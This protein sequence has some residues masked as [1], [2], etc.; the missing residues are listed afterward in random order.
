MPDRPNVLFIVVDQFRADLLHGALAD[1][2]DLPNLRALMADSVSFAQHYSV[3]SPCGPAR[4]SLLT[5]QYAMN[6]GV[7]RNGTPLAHDTPNIAREARRAGY[8]PLLFGYTDIAIDPR[9]HDPA[10]PVLRTYEQ[11]LPGVR[12]GRRNAD[13]GKLALARAPVVAGL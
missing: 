2:V 9:M 8:Q 5:G 7:V 12:R 13:G 4:A 6:H 1:H 10:D 3:T 11:V